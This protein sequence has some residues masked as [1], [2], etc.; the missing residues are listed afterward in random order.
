LEDIVVA[1]MKHKLI[2][3]DPQELKNN[4]DCIEMAGG[5]HQTKYLSSSPA[6]STGISCEPKNCVLMTKA[7]LRT[8]VMGGEVDRANHVKLIVT[9]A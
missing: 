5:L 9:G 3:F 7:D 4:N 6:T 8:N 2:R 1:G